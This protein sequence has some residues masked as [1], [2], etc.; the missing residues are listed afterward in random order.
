MDTNISYV[1]RFKPRGII[2]VN[3]L[4]LT[5]IWTVI[6][7]SATLRKI[8]PPFS[9]FDARFTPLTPTKTLSANV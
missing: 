6:I 7:V 8:T 2:N 3:E 5:F 1:P 9:L 4:A